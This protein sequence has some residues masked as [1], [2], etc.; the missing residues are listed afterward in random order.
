MLKKTLLA[1]ALLAGFAAAGAA[2]A[3][4]SITLYG[5]VDAG[6]GYQNYKYDRGGADATAKS[7]GLR[8]GTLNGSRFGLKGSEDLG[9]GLRAIFQLEQGFDIGTGQSSSDRQFHRQAFAGLSSD[10]WGSLT[11]GRQYSAGVDTFLVDNGFNMGDADKVF[12]SMGMNEGNR[13]DNSFKYTTPSLSGFQAIVMYGTGDSGRLTADGYEAS[14]TVGRANGVSF[15]DRGSRVS[16]GL[17]YAGGSISAGASYD[18]QSVYGDDIGGGDAS[19]ATNWQI[20]GA[21][22]FEVVKLSLAYGQD[23]HGKI[24]WGGSVEDFA[25][26]EG[27]GLGNFFGTD[28]KSNNYHVG[29]SAPVAGGTLYAGWGY[30]TSNAD[31]LAPGGAAGDLSG[32]ISTYHLNYMYP[33]SKRTS[34][35]AYGTYGRNLAY[36]RDLKGTEAGVGLS[37]SF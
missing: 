8:D 34:V 5:I 24:G 11:M 22:D 12:G 9:D 23:R 20:N 33:L 6:Y 2:R 19:A 4:T 16:L 25:D 31:D 13:V 18:R 30:S 1:A 26:F 14:A 37:H 32:S 27:L 29:L 3:E 21:Y 35:Y 28:F 7:S 36:V 17:L 15:D 10:A